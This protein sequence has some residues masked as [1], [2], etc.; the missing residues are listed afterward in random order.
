MTGLF[1]S[2]KK[3]LKK[4]NGLVKDMDEI[5]DKI[6]FNQSLHRLIKSNIA[7]MVW[8]PEEAFLVLLKTDNQLKKAVSLRSSQVEYYLKPH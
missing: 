8:G 3:H 5:I 2:Q 1:I 6:E 4:T 7:E